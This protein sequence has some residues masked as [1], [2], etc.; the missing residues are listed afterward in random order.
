M[1]PITQNKLINLDS[2]TL[3]DPVALLEKCFDAF[4]YLAIWGPRQLM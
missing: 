2:A 3:A 4:C 1:I